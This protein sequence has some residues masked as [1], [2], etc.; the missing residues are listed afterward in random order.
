MITYPIAP[1]I[2]FKA[3]ECC[4]CRAVMKSCDLPSV[5]IYCG[6][7]NEGF[8]L[9][10]KEEK[11]NGNGT[12]SEVGIKQGDGGRSGRNPRGSERKH[13]LD[14]QE[15]GGQAGGGGGQGAS[16]VL[17]AIEFG[18]ASGGFDGRGGG[19]KVCRSAEKGDVG[20]VSSDGPA[21]S[22]GGMVGQGG[23]HR[24]VYCLVSCPINRFGDM[25]M[26]GVRAFHSQ[27]DCLDAL[28]LN[29]TGLNYVQEVIVQ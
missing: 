13:Q 29:P 20:R 1:K 15:N 7:Y 8:K 14:R 21:T 28:R 18:G 12:E 16:G 27:D 25:V 26:L 4:E 9:S 11:S 3:W 23:E 22:S 24:A 5:C 10:D 2:D 6:A 19:E 17:A